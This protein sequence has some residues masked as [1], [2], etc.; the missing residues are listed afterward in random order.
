MNVK[1]ILE[2]LS[3]E[4]LPKEG[5]FFR[6]TYRSEDSYSAGANKKA[7]STA[8]YYMLAE[9]QV[10]KIHRLKSDEIWHFYFGDPVEIF[11]L[12]SDGHVEMKVLGTRLDNNEI[13]QLFIPKDVWQ[14]AR[15]KEKGKF[16]L[17]GTTVS[18][19]F[20]EGDFEPGI[21]EKLLALY[22]KTTEIIT[23]LT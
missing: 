15:L 5:G 23:S 7:L 10:S 6:E 8:I 1:Q 9:G 19:A 18:P 3:L 21:R 14:G 12:F 11:L 20:E 2:L 4:P 13:P 22:P 16:A 17:M